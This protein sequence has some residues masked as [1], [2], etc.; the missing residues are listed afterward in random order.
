[1]IVVLA[2]PT[3]S[4]S[5]PEPTSD[6]FAGSYSDPDARAFAN[7]NA[8]PF[9]M[10]SVNAEVNP[11]TYSNVLSSMF[12]RG[13]NLMRQFLPTGFTISGMVGRFF[14]TPQNIFKL[15]KHLLF[16][17]PQEIVLYAIQAFCK[18]NFHLIVLIE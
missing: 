13:E 11:E 5:I 10:P 7:P 12:Q 14:P 17:L 1:M 2:I 18:S 6:T 15:T 9:A 4:E 3:W 8:N 16:E